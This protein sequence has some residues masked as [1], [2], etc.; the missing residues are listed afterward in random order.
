MT[1][2]LAH[3]RQTTSAERQRDRDD[4]SRLERGLVPIHRAKPGRAGQRS[5][6]CFLCGRGWDDVKFGRDHVARTG[7][8]VKY[9]RPDSGDFS[10]SGYGKWLQFDTWAQASG[11]YGAARDTDQIEARA[12]V[13][14]TPVETFEEGEE[15]RRQSANRNDNLNI[16]CAMIDW[17]V[18]Q[19]SKR[20]KGQRNVFDGSLD[21]ASDLGTKQPGEAGYT[22]HKYI[23]FQ[24]PSRSND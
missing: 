15:R 21:S 16:P 20:R 1:V 8:T 2:T 5:V 4:L 11:L 13:E 6:A 17:L 3:E 24:T 19:D 12:I 10:G 23:R 18:G 7:H 14:A 22:G 9:L